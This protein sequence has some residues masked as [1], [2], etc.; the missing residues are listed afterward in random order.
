MCVSV[1]TYIRVCVCM[2]VCMCV[3]VCMCLC[4][5][6]YVCLCVRTYVCVCI[7]V[8]ALHSE[9]FMLFATLRF[10]TARDT[11]MLANEISYI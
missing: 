4:V 5:R 3:C 10:S 9:T 1:C 11:S 2:C 6:R 7:L 8:K